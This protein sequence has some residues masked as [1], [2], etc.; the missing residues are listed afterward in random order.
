MESYFFIP[1]NSLNFNNILASES[2]SPRAFYEKRGFGFKRSESVEANPFLN[3]LLAYSKIPEFEIYG[4]EREE[5]PLYIGIPKKYIEENSVFK[6]GDLVLYRIPKVVY[7]NWI[8]CFFVVNTLEERKKLIAGTKRSLEVKNSNEYQNRIYLLGETQIDKIKWSE[9]IINNIQDISTFPYDELE[10]ERNNNRIKGLVYGYAAGWIR[11]TSPELIE[12]K[13]YFREFINTFSVLI[14]EFSQFSHGKINKLP[15]DSERNIQREINELRGLQQK[16]K[17]LLSTIENNSLENEISESFSLNDVEIQ[18]IKEH[19]YKEGGISLYQLVE[20]FLKTKHPEVLSIS[21]LLDI[22]NSFATEFLNQP[23]QY[24][25]NQLKERL[26]TDK[27]MIQ[28]KFNEIENQHARENV[29][30]EIPF[31]AS[32]FQESLEFNFSDLNKIENDYLNVILCELIQYVEISSSDEI[33]QNLKSILTKIGKTVKTIENHG[34]DDHRYLQ[35]LYKGITTV[36]LPFK[37]SET[38]KISLQALAFVLSRHSDIEKL[39]DYMV[40]NKFFNF[41]YAYMIWGILYGY[42]NLS[43][44]QLAPIAANLDLPTT[45]AEFS[46]SLSGQSSLSSVKIDKYLNS[47]D[48]SE[49]PLKTVNWDYS[50]TPG[51]EKQKAQSQISF[52]DAKEEIKSENSF[53]SLIQSE[54][55]DHPD[56]L[57]VIMESYEKASNDNTVIFVDNDTIVSNFQNHLLK[58]KSNKASERLKGFGNKKIEAA[59]KTLEIF[60][61][62]KTDS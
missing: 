56:W 30:D 58:E 31:K 37:I 21:D 3:S 1:T 53:E 43:K 11:E 51:S 39:H 4:T 52:K 9:S 46:A 22:L 19:S 40:K 59:T 49:R 29:Y 47:E 13:N 2:I 17:T 36:G 26:N 45:L 7:I 25:L 24:K 55:Q 57:D 35:N 6:F 50:D 54:F 27:T 10:R 23:S 60:L 5:F 44:V 16:I 38:D 32:D 42:A 28:K 14:N 33:S 15:H 12:S 61:S 48:V 18:F 8:E 62:R 34:E 20:N 41:R